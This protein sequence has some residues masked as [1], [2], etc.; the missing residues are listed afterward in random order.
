MYMYILKRNVFSSLEHYAS[1]PWFKHILIQGKHM[2]ITYKIWQSRIRTEAYKL[3][4]FF[5]RNMHLYLYKGEDVD[6]NV[7]YVQAALS[8][9]TFTLQEQTDYICYYVKNDY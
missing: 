1:F 8:S 7:Q 2:Y 6:I 9:H 4:L 5:S 3:I